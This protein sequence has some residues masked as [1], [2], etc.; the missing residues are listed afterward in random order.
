M[1][2]PVSDP[3]AAKQVKLA[4]ALALPPELPPGAPVEKRAKT[5][6]P[7]ADG[8]EEL[9]SLTESSEEE[10]DEEGGAAPNLLLCQFE[11]VKKSK[12]KDSHQWKVKLR[13]GLLSTPDKDYRFSVAHAV[14]KRW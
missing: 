9:S 5:E 6:V 11:T 14:L 1:E 13:N 3:S 8:E 12:T 2:P 10:K 4:T 7:L